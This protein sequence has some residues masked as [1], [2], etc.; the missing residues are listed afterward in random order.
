MCLASFTGG[1]V[2]NIGRHVRIQNPQSMREALTIALAVTEAERFEKTSEIFFADT[3]AG[4]PTRGSNNREHGNDREA[5]R[6]NR[7]RGTPGKCY[8]CKGYD[9]LGREC[10]TRLKRDSGFHNAHINRIAHS[11]SVSVKQ[12]TAKCQTGLYLRQGKPT[13]RVK[14]RGVNREFIVYRGSS[15]SLIK[16]GS[17][18]VRLDPPARPHSERR[19]EL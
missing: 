16:P 2:G 13:V 9:H 5:P 8:E 6:W 14:I 4:R 7:N 12:T 11:F 1:L 10:P 3:Q 18:A 15:V 19:E 17:A